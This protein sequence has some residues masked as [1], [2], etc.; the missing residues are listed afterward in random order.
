MEMG[1]LSPECGEGSKGTIS[2]GCASMEMRVWDESVETK[3]CER[4]LF[5]GILL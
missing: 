2:W 1:A 4:E 5:P 3:T